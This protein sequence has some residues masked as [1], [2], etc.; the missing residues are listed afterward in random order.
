M[1]V[2]WLAPSPASHGMAVQWLATTIGCGGSPLIGWL[3][4]GWLHHQPLHGPAIAWLSHGWLHRQP[5][6][7]WSSL[8]RAVQWLAIARLWRCPDSD[9][10]PSESCRGRGWGR[11]S[12]RRACR[13]S[14]ERSLR[15]QGSAAASETG[16]PDRIIRGTGRH[17]SR[18]AGVP[19][20][21]AFD[22]EPAARPRWGRAGRSRARRRIPGG[23]TSPGGKRRVGAPGPEGRGPR[24]PL[25]M[26]GRPP[27]GQSEPA[28][29]D[30]RPACRGRGKTGAPRP[31]CIISW[32]G[33][34]HR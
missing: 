3:S 16:A 1:V 29:A 14:I 22:S 33:S 18:L 25:S 5:A 9:A 6:I 26:A 30:G 12:A 4:H 31:D 32:V 24:R 2:P 13:T 28:P 34:Q 19:G 21:C 15:G 8:C 17:P 20:P 27:V 11:A 23:P 10:C 7:A